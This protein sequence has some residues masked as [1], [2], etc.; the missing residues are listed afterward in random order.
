MKEKRYAAS[1]ALL[2]SFLIAP[3]AYADWGQAVPVENV[4]GG[5]PIES[6]DGLTLF[7]AGGFDGTLDV[8]IYERDSLGAP[9]G[10]RIK[11]PDPVSLDTTADFCPT[12][13]EGDVLFFVSDRVDDTSC[14]GADMF[15]TRI[16]D[17]VPGAPRRL[18]CAPYRPCSDR[19]V[20]RPVCV[21]CP[22][23]RP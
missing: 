10:P 13:L 22:V 15:V 3:S 16:K 17:G 12:P 7:T 23:H 4:A 9:F 8:W 20:R 18:A 5:C 11:V 2:A 19:T 14:G 6:P 1:A 21:A